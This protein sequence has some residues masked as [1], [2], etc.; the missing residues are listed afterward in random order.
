MRTHPVIKH[1][2]M[3]QAMQGTG[4]GTTRAAVEADLQR[5][6]QAHSKAGLRRLRGKVSWG[7]GLDET[8]QGH[9]TPLG[10]GQWV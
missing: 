2:L 4:L 6:I 5:L 10:H 9:H 1:R 8:R 3:Q 7:E